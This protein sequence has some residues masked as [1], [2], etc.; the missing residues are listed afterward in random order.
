MLQPYTTEIVGESD[1]AKELRQFVRT[2]ARSTAPILLLGEAGTG[3]ELV[4]RAI[5]F[6]SARRNSPFL[7]ID[8]SLFYESELERELF[9]YRPGKGEPEEAARQGLLEFALRGSFYAANVEEL[10]PSI[11]LRI[12]NFLDT[13]YLQPVGSDQLTPSRM[14]LIFSSE[15]NLQGF[16]EGGLFSQ[17]L[18]SRF[19]GLTRHIPPLRER[20][21]DIVPLVRHF[22]DRYA[23]ECGGR[24]GDCKIA[25][26]A[27][28]AF[29]HY[30]WPGNVDELKGEIGRILAQGHRNITP[31][32]LTNS[33]VH[34]WRVRQGDPE[35][36]QVMEE[37][38]GHIREFRVMS[39][40]DAEY[41][42]VLLDTNDWDVMFK[43]YER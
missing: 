40:L 24:A 43:S 36:V 32:V 11:Q 33:I 20:P 2:A 31:Q 30:H 9:G 38:E 26:S 18:F 13:G 12:L 17:E 22:L 25:D 37:L 15:K 19:A 6:A 1:V 4:A 14:R 7:M 39:R 23:M 34:H 8:C 10:S 28:E 27:V 42:D 41:G 5:H 35:V 21:E 29:R 3:K 16:S